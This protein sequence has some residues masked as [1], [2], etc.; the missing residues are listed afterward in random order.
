[1]PIKR[2]LVPGSFDPVT[3]GH[4][5]IIS[6][7]AIMF[8]EVRVVVANNVGKSPLFTLEERI[9][10]LLEV[11]AP[12]ANVSVDTF[13]GLLVQYAR[14]HHATVIVKGLRAVSDFEYELQMAL[15]NRRLADNVETVFLMTGA[16]YSYLSSNIVK[17]IARLGGAVE[18]LVPDSV[19]RRLRQKLAGR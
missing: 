17:E 18:G 14:M 19:E 11:C 9:E 10:M 4:L 16:E 3:N 2:A 15:M 8:D 12:Y 6:R 1:M 7:S 13:D 5:D